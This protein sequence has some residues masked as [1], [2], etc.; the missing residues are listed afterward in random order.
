MAYRYSDYK[1]KENTIGPPSR[2]RND[3]TF[4]DA[5]N[6]CGRQN[7]LSSTGYISKWVVDFDKG[8]FD[9]KLIPVTYWRIWFSQFF[10]YLKYN[11]I[12]EQ[13]AATNY[14][15]KKEWLYQNVGRKGDKW[16]ATWSR[17]HYEIYYIGFK[18]KEDAVRFKLIFNND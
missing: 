5:I 1:Y 9:G 11:V 18:N 17:K 3:K 12:L 14:P 8:K 10:F 16:D 6:F 13:T 7:L 2:Y 4:Q 15:E